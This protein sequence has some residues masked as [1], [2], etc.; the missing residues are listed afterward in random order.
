[1]AFS[2]F[3]GINLKKRSAVKEVLHATHPY[4]FIFRKPMQPYNIIIN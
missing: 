2:Y 4:S 3:G 1:M